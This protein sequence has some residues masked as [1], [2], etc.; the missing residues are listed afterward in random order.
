MLSLVSLD[1][2]VVHAET[3]HQALQIRVPSAKWL[4]SPLQLGGP[5]AKALC[6]TLQDGND[7]QGAEML[8]PAL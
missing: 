6:M 4:C 7:I 2:V 5:C 1:Y 8:Y 3:L